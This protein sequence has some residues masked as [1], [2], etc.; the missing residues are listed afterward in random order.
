MC[1]FV[2]DI[3]GGVV[4]VIGSV[5]EFVIDNA[6]PIISTIAMNYIAPGFGGY[7]SSTFGLSKDLGL[8][9]AKGIG[10]AAVSA[11]NGGSLANIATAG[12]TP[13]IPSIGKSLG[14]NL[15]PTGFIN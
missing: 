11:I 3:I 7:L 9:V 4:D 5:A 2:G 1:G 14:I 13:F 12:L 10:S 8:M 6:F 15:D